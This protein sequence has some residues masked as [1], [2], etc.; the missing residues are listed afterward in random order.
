MKENKKVQHNLDLSG[1]TIVNARLVKCKVDGVQTSP[2]VVEDIEDLTGAQLDA[3]K[4]GDVIVKGS[5]GHEHAY[6]VAYKDE[7]KGELSLVYTDHENIEEVY[8]E[9]TEGEWAFVVKQIANQ[10]YNVIRPAIADYLP[11]DASALAMIVSAV[12]RGTIFDCILQLQPEGDNQGRVVGAS[13]TFKNVVYIDA[14]DSSINGIQIDY[15]I[16]ELEVLADIQRAGNYTDG[17]PRF[18]GVNGFI[19]E[20]SLGIYVCVGGKKISYTASDGKIVS[21]EISNESPAQGDDVVE[22]P[23]DN[24]EKLIGANIED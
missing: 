21:A 24:V 11:N 18:E 7:D 5:N 8:Y 10:D 15:T 2:K 9:K 13:E 4:C 23:A 22:I 12:E 20:S 16:P 6:V 1:K 19:Q 17:L 3:L 14:E